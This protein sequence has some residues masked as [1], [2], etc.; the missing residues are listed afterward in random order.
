MP[1]IKLEARGVRCLECTGMEVKAAPG[2]A[3]TDTRRCLRIEPARFVS[4]EMS[5]NC[6]EFD[7]V[8][9]DVVAARDAWVARLPPWFDRR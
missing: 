2:L 6:W 5:R 7:P 1:L 8:P 3:K 9:P 4:I